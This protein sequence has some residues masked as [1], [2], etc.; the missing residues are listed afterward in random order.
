MNIASVRDSD[1]EPIIQTVAEPLQQYLQKAASTGKSTPSRSAK[2][3]TGKDAIATK[4]IVFRPTHRQ[5]LAMLHILDDG[6]REQGEMIRIRDLRWTIGRD[7][8]DTVIPF[9]GDMSGRHAE[10]RCQRQKGRFRWFLIDRKSTNGTFVRAFRASLS[11]DSEL[12]L[13]GRRYVFQLPEPGAEATETEA[14]QT[15]AYRA[16]TRTLLEQFV[17]RLIEVGVSNENPRAFVVGEKETWIGSDERCEVTIGD[18]P[19]ISPQHAR[20]YQ[21]ETGRWMIEDRKSVNGVWIRVKKFAMD[22]LT[23]FQLGQ[24]RFRF[25]PGVDQQR[26][27]S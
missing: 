13:G 24:Q 19:F 1:E 20:I 26:P 21:D 16:P 23:E 11:R 3:A 6:C 5:P 12:I 25:H 10:L 8:G 15:Q 9:D 4:A 7:K 22:K 2:T 27:E 18:D 14:L 17:P